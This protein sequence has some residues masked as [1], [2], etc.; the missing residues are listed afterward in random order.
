MLCSVEGNSD[1]YLSNYGHEKIHFP[2]KYSSVKIGLTTVTYY[3]ES[4]EISDYDSYENLEE[5]QK[6]HYCYQPNETAYLIEPEEEFRS[7]QD[8]AEKDITKV[9]LNSL[10]RNYKIPSH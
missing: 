4:I 2:Q 3:L 10:T 6:H 7:T 5:I 8:L 9:Q 1:L